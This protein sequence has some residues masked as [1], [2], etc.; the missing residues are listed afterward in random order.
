MAYL[1]VL[2]VP[3]HHNFRQLSRLKDLLSQATDY[4]FY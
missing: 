4:V 1:L 3:L 2:Y